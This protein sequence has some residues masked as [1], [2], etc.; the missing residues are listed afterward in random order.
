MTNTNIIGILEKTERLEDKFPE[1]GQEYLREFRDFN[2]EKEGAFCGYGG[3]CRLVSA[4]YGK[5]CA[6]ECKDEDEK[7]PPEFRHDSHTELRKWFRSFKSE[8][9]F[10]KVY[11]ALVRDHM[12][13]AAE[14]ERLHSS[15][16]RLVRKVFD[17]AQK[18][19]YEYTIFPIVVEGGLYK[20]FAMIL[21]DDTRIPLKYSR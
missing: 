15:T 7:I 17:Y 18:N 13:E 10:E 12:A 9:E 16:K 11:Q 8:A 21:P 4:C 6:E 5:T 2:I 19:G 20:R 3:E 14:S 1:I